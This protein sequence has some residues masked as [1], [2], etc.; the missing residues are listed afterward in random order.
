MIITNNE[1]GITPFTA[2]LAALVI[3]MAKASFQQNI[4]VGVPYHGRDDAA[5][6]GEKR[7]A[8]CQRLVLATRMWVWMRH[9]SWRFV[10]ACTSVSRAQEG[11]LQPAESDRGCGKSGHAVRS[12]SSIIII[13]IM[14]IKNS[15][16][17]PC[18]RFRNVLRCARPSLHT[19]CPRM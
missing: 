14:R 3:L 17:C 18:F 5:L 9:I 8:R 2:Y 6:C 1:V 4:I 16:H 7:L 19:R 13:I 12:G 10:F 11:R 15:A